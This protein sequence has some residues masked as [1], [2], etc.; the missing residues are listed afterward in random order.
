MSARY[1]AGHTGNLEVEPLY[2]QAMPLLSYSNLCSNRLCRQGLA[3]CGRRA[4]NPT[5]TGS[6]GRRPGPVW[7]RTAVSG[8]LLSA[9]LRA[10]RPV[11][12]PLPIA[13]LLCPLRS[14]YAQQ[15]PPHAHF[16]KL[17]CA[18][19]RAWMVLCQVPTQLPQAPVSLEVQR[20]DRTMAPSAGPSRVSGARI[21]PV[22]RRH[23]RRRTS[24]PGATAAAARVRA[25]GSSCQVAGWRSWR[26][27]GPS[28]GR[29][30]FA[31]RWPRP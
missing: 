31:S 6:Q 19:C 29:G 21:Q 10:V 7:I 5:A 15:L 24:C 8:L 2:E 26:S 13:G 18:V 4:M 23:D 12:P 1:P 16:H 20:R 27:R 30:C 3:S 17:Q 22:G 28:S 9:W 25:A 11:F 14:P